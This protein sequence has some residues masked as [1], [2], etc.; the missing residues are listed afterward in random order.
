MLSEAFLQKNWPQRELNSALNIEASSGQVR[1]LP[2]LSGRKE[3]KKRIFREYPILNDKSYL[4]W[5]NDANVIVEALQARLAKTDESI[6]PKPTQI[7]KPALEVPLPKI[8]KKFT[9][10]DKDIFLKY[11]FDKIRSYFQ[12]ALSHLQTQNP[13]VKTDLTEIHKFK[14]TCTI[15]LHGDVSNRCK[16]WV[17]GPLSSDSIAY[18]EGDFDFDQEGSCNDWLTISDEGADL[19]LKPVGFGFVGPDI[20]KDKALSPEKAAEYFWL[21]FTEHLKY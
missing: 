7:Q 19:G 16:I 14:F 21:H 20:E 11:S 4:S 9:Q 18:Y 10:R 1:V 17:G 5:N 2:L 8:K 13:D 6:P 3:T 12:T 15:Y